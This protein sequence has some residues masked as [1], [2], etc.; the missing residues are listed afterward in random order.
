MPATANNRAFLQSG[1]SSVIIVCSIEMPMAIQSTRVDKMETTTPPFRG[2]DITELG[3]PIGPTWRKRSAER[4]GVWSLSPTIQ[5][6]PIF[7]KFSNIH[8]R[9]L[10]RH[11][12]AANS[13]DLMLDAVLTMLS[14]C[15]NY[16]NPFFLNPD[17]R[18]LTAIDKVDATPA[19][20]SK[21]YVYAVLMFISSL[22]KAESDLQHLWFG[23]RAATRV[24]SELMAAIYDKAL[25]RKD[26]SGIVDKDKQTEK[27]DDTTSSPNG[28][29]DKSKKKGKGKD[30]D[31]EKT[32][33]PKAGADVGKIVNLMA[34]D[35]NRICQVVTGLYLIYS[36]PLEI[37]IGCAYLYH[38]LGI[39]AFAGFVILF[40]GWPLNTLLAKRSIRIQ[41]GNLAARDKRMG[42]LNE[43]IGAV[44]INP[45]IKMSLHLTPAQVKF[46]K[47][48]AWEE[49]WIDRA[50]DARGQ[51]MK[52]MVK[53]TVF[54]SQGTDEL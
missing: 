41:K 38:L 15:F 8:R 20:R 29:A 46:I 23:R 24:R 2:V 7:I 18:I 36:A 48:F 13:L 42:V 51:E 5:S 43:L 11:L 47:F 21:A 31:A 49:R 32:D 16:L 37:I 50:M 10:L 28:S 52:W 3:L 1:G 26:Y 12:W 45:A 53:G 35:A 39:S 34:G 19:D 6:R 30:K 40:A 44:S 4:Q 22:A 9:T 14:T 33:D 25:K 27:K 54:L 17:S